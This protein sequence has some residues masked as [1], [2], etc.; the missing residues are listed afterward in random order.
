MKKNRMRGGREP[1]IKQKIL[2]VAKLTLVLFF[3]GLMQVSAGQYS[4]TKKLTLKLQNNG[5]VATKTL[6][7]GLSIRE[8]GT[9]SFTWTPEKDMADP[10]TLVASHNMSDDK[11]GNDSAS[12]TLGSTP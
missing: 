6:S 11:S 4:S 3:L 5:V 2:W 8:S 7:G 1:S 12:T 9:L 10:V